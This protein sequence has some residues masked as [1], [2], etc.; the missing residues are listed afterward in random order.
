MIKI[1]SI[2]IRGYEFEKMMAFWMEVLHDVA[3]YPPRDGWVILCDP[4]GKGPNVS[5]DK[6]PENVTENGADCTLIICGKSAAGS[7]K[8][9]EAWRETLP[10]ALQTPR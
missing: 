7:G 3:K 9:D 5:L 2:V 6:V 8:I 4:E 1:G 10:V